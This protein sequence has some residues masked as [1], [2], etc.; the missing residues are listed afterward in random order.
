[1]PIITLLFE[2]DKPMFLQDFIIENDTDVTFTEI[3]VRQST[4]SIWGINV[5]GGNVLT[6]NEQ[7]IIAFKPGSSKTC[8][9]DIRTRLLNGKSLLFE[10]IN[11]CS[12]EKV[13]LYRYQGKPYHGFD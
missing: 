13:V 8:L 11:L 3:Y 12:Q 10:N 2:F 9:Y 1:M 6:R 7:A 5:L 4:S